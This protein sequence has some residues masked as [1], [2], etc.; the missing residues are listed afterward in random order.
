MRTE[1]I[2]KK[3][4]YMKL[5]KYLYKTPVKTIR[6]DYMEYK[7]LRTEQRML[8]DKYLC[9]YSALTID[10]GQVAADSITPAKACISRYWYSYPDFGRDS[11]PAVRPIR[12]MCSV[13]SYYRPCTF[14]KCIYHTRNANYF[15][16]KREY[17]EFVKIC[18][19]YWKDK[20]EQCK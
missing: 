8:R 4:P 17:D 14:S 18:A 13:F 6:A 5:F 20:Y 11:D 12:E 1:Q 15:K 9:A 7:K 19:K 2:N 16:V 10:F 3:R